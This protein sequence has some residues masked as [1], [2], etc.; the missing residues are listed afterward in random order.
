[1]RFSKEERFFLNLVRVSNRDLNV[2]K[3]FPNNTDRHEVAKFLVFM[4]LRKLGKNVLIEPIFLNGKRADIF[5]ISDGTVYEV[6]HSE[7]IQELNEKIKDYPAE[8]EVVPM[9]S[10]SILKNLKDL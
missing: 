2:F 8:V 5:C 7:T 6:L 9:S 10:D 3:Y 1:M 4:E